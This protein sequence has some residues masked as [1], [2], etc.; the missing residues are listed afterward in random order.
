MT[1]IARLMRLF[2]GLPRAY[3]IFHLKGTALP[4]EKFKGEARTVQLPVDEAVWSRHVAGEIQLGIVPIRDDATCM[5]GA[6]D[7]DDYKTDHAALERKLLKASL[8]LV[9]C[10]SKSGGAHLYAFFKQPVMAAAARELLA[11]WAATLGYGNVEIFPKQDALLSTEDTGNW[12][13]MPYCSGDETQRYAI[14]GD[15]RLSLLDFLALA[16]TRLIEPSIF[17][18]AAEFPELL[19]Q[20]P[21]CLVTF[22]T[23]GFP[24]GTRNSGLF[25]LG[26]YCKKRW[27]DD[28]EAKLHEMNAAFM[29]PPLPDDEVAQVARHLAKKEYNYRC[30]DQPLVSVCQRNVCLKRKYGVS[31][32]DMQLT[33]GPQLENVVRLET[34][35]VVYFADFQGRRIQFRSK[36]INSQN[37]MREL[38]IE[39]TNTML[40]QMPPQRYGQWADRVLKSATISEAPPEIAEWQTVFDFLEEYC[41][42]HW[43]AK[44]WQDVVDGGAYEF[45]GRTYFRPH[46]FV[47]AVNK[48]HRTRLSKSDVYQALLKA[49]VRSETKRIG[50]K[51]HQLWSVPAFEKPDNDK[52]AL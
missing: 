52:E 29:S 18:S 23:Q 37:L 22:G 40:Q 15:H 47:Q 26:V 38:L 12:I 9:M 13:N 46:K 3:G 2:D 34:Q 5:F 35:P 41:I 14:S 51:D 16:E 24:E 43:P 7:V 25:S 10:R 11:G 33:F 4:G 28:W 48:E 8:P 42:E 19:E 39:Q 49:S 45:E 32:Q 50:K 27:G 20:G 36:D 30:K 21:P 17:E 6:I 1:S 31:G 44:A